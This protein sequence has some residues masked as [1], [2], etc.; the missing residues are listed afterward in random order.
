MI[1]TSESS[2]LLVSCAGVSSVGVVEEAFMAVRG[3]V[4]S[5]NGAP[6]AGQ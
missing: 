3:F 1:R 6:R 2:R 4:T 5:T